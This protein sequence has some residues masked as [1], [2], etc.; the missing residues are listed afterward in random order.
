[1]QKSTVGRDSVTDY[2]LRKLLKPL[3]DLEN[4]NKKT[5]CNPVN[6]GSAAMVTTFVGSTGDRTK[7]EWKFLNTVCQ[8]N[9][10]MKN[11]YH[12]DY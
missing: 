9:A 12:I 7:G 3:L 11:D 4:V 8:T 5:V 2:Q 10:G 6:F 1:M